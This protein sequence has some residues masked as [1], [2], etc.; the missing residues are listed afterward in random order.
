MRAL[1]TASRTAWALHSI[2][3]ALICPALAVVASQVG[4]HYFPLRLGPRSVLRQSIPIFPIH[5]LR[6]R[7]ARLDSC[8]ESCVGLIQCLSHSPGYERSRERAGSQAPP[9]SARL[10]DVQK[11]K[12]TCA[13]SICHCESRLQCSLIS[14]VTGC[15]RLAGRAQT[16]ARAVSTTARSSSRN[17]ILCMS[18][19]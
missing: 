17:I 16:W 1:L 5:F 11:S 14:S 6:A 3:L 13:L 15:G 2:D 7:T 4:C 12:I 18:S 8:S 19:S 9:C 10:Q